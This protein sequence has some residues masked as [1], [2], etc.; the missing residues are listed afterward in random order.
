MKNS[1]R[2]L[3]QEHQFVLLWKKKTPPP[4]STATAIIIR[5]TPATLRKITT[6]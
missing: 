4:P 6:N 1:A 2:K 3:A 5:A